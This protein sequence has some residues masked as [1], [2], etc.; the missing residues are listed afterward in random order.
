MPKYRVALVAIVGI[1]V[2]SLGVWLYLQ[3][4]NTGPGSDTV[5][6]CKWKYVNDGIPNTCEARCKESYKGGGLTQAGEGDTTWL[7]C[8][9][10]GYTNCP[11]PNGG[12]ICKRETGASCS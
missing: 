8:C 7:Y 6:V 9:P 5:E 10:I 2:F 4:R 11:A 3:S 1:A 12:R